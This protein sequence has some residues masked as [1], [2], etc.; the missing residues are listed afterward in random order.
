MPPTQ[1]TVNPSDTDGDAFQHANFFA[2]T[3]PDGEPK[4][5]TDCDAF[6]HTDGFS[7][8]HTYI[9]PNA[10][11]ITRS[12]SMHSAMLSSSPTSNPRMAAI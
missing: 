8:G 2:V 4:R 5:H 9:N 10:M 1:L 12:S 7:V 3:P 11:P 6:Q